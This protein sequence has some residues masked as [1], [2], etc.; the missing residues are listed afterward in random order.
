MKDRYLLIL[1]AVLLVGAVGV[2]FLYVP[3]LP[4]IGSIVVLI[5]LV[6][7]FSLG[8][9]LGQNTPALSG[10]NEGPKNPDLPVVHHADVRE[11][12]RDVA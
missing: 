10:Q 12:F 1:L 9:H 4:V 7:M 3:I 2:F 6:A 5:A 8:F 11:R